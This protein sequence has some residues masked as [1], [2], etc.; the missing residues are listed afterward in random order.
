MRFR[1]RS[2]RCRFGLGLW[3][4]IAALGRLALAGALPAQAAAGRVEGMVV[5]PGGLP[6]AEVRVVVERPDGDL[7]RETETDLHGISA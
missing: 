5:N 4:E 7:A 1:R 2:K 6:A 3:Q